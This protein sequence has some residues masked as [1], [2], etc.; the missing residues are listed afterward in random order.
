MRLITIREPIIK[1]RYITVADLLA[2]CLKS[3]LVRSGDGGDGTRLLLLFANLG[4]LGHVSDTI[5]AD[6]RSRE[7]CLP[8]GVARFIPSLHAFLIPQQ[9]GLQPAH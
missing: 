8:R 3:F 9:Q 1:F 5:N 7:D 2:E 6:V 4:P